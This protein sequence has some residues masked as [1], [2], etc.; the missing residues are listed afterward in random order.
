MPLFGEI[1]LSE[2]IGKPL[3]DPKGEVAGRVKDVIAVKGDPLPKISA[4]ITERKRQLY[5]VRWEDI[6][7]LNRKIISTYLYA[8]SLDPYTMNEYDLLLVRDVLDK[9]IVDANGAKVVRVNDIKL[10]G[11]NADAVLVAVDM[12]VRGILRRLNIER[13]GEKFLKLFQ[14]T[15]PH[16]LVSWNYIQ[17]LKP[18][19]K[20]IT[21]TVPRQLISELHPADIAEIISQVPRDEGANFLKDLDVETAAETL[22]EL[23]PEVQAEMISSME[24]AKAADILEEMSP[25]KAA[26][27]LGDLPEEKTTELLEHIEREEALDIKELLSHEEDT[28]GGIMTNEFIA[29]PPDITVREAIERFKKDAREMVSVHYIFIVDGE[30]RLVGVTSL[31]EMILADPSMRLSEIMETKLI[32]VAPGE[33][34]MIVAE[35][36][37]KYNL[38]AVPVV[39]A[40]GVLLGIAKIDDIIDRILPPAAKRGRRAP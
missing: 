17:P 8:G 36:V 28:A 4:I 37:S 24:A 23:K 11:Y 15:L 22:S 39:D 27:V 7:L 3:L 33:D 14:M 34:E 26:D 12:G 9:Q 40:K 31:K 18:K 16:N 25:D 19:L 2:F 13:R 20:T 5:R 6:N 29:Y 1:F 32:T 30:E 35:T 21:L 38:V 10:E